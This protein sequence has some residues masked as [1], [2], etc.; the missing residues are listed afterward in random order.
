MVLG[1]ARLQACRVDIRVDV[2]SGRFCTFDFQRSL[3]PR[4]SQEPVAMACNCLDVTLVSSQNA[5]QIGDMAS[6]C[7]FFY[8]SIGPDS[9]QQVLLSSQ[10]PRLLGQQCQ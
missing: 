1:G 6:Q 3:W 7:S 5:P 2:R 10:F 8:A 4:L 9:V